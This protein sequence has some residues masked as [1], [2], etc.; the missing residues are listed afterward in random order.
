M[1]IDVRGFLRHLGI[2]QPDRPSAETLFRLH[3]AYVE[4]VP[5]ESVQFQLGRKT[6]LDPADVAERIINR[7]SGGYCYQL[8]GAFS[9]L[10]TEL[11][12]QVTLHRGGVHKRGRSAGVNGGHLV[13]TVTDLPETPGVTW[14]VDAGLGDGLHVPL[15]LQIGSYEQEPFTFALRPSEVT[16]D[17]WR[18]DH[19]PRGGIEGMD[20]A[21]ARTEL[22]AF[23]ESHDYLSTSPD[24]PFVRLCS[25]FRRTS[26]AVH[27]LRGLTQ[28]SVHPDRTD[29]CTLESKAEWYASLRDVFGLHLAD[30]TADDR[31]RL[32]RR[33]V[34]QH[35][36]YLATLLNPHR[37]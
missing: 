32:W 13:L 4:T 35:E 18:L 25:A 31:D 6:P 22:A 29:V 12:Y 2:R 21:R 20:F 16:A 5:Y 11:G 24:S 9:A 36:A 1:P 17:G 26:T 23:R 37:G 28:S 7:Q 15:P 8:N 33:V 27:I 10:L 3:A 34:A 14:L 19:D 30:L